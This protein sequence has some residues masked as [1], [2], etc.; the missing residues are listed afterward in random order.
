MVNVVVLEWLRVC[1][2]GCF[3]G[4]LDLTKVQHP[5][6]KYQVVIVVIRCEV[7]YLFVLIQLSFILSIIISID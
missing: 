2:R 6:I 1:E 4:K 3:V 7:L 5:L